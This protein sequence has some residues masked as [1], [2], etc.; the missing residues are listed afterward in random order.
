MFVAFLVVLTVVCFWD[1][2]YN[3]GVLTGGLRA[4]GR[5]I[6]HHMGL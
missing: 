2:E 1:I 6:S 4:M 3:N 5:S